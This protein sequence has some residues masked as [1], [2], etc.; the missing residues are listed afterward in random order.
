MPAGGLL[1]TRE[2]REANYELIGCDAS[3]NARYASR[4]SLDDANRVWVNACPERYL[5]QYRYRG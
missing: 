5:K 3:N 1:A 2:G 4:Q